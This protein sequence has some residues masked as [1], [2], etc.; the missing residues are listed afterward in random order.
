MWK[1]HWKFRI[2]TEKTNHCISKQ[3]SFLCLVH[4]ASHV[5]LH[6]FSYEIVL[7]GGEDSIIF[8]D[9]FSQPEHFDKMSKHV[10]I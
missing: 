2:S 4:F 8:V 5:S 1:L 9:V 3:K 6:I 10:L 7:G